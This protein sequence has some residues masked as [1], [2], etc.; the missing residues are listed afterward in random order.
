MIFKF[1]PFEPILKNG[2][3]IRIVYLPSCINV[4]KF[5]PNP[6]IGMEGIVQDIDDESFTLFTGTSYLANINIKS[7]KFIN[8]C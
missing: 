6:Y 1:K 5:T 3:K 2:D 7:C 8:L 4:P